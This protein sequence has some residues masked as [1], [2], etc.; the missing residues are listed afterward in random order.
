MTETRVAIV[1]AAS[2]G[3]G[4]AI[5][6]CLR[7]RGYGLALMSPSGGSVALAE[8]L[9]AL[10]LVGS[11]TA[12]ADIDRLLAATLDRYGRI[13]GVVNNT[14]RHSDVL[15]RYGFTDAPP[16]TGPNLNYDPAFEGEVL[17]VPDAAWHDDLDLMVLNVVR[18]ARATTDALKARSGGSVVNI[19]GLEGAQPRIV[20]PLGPVRLALHAFT[21]LYA[22]RYARD[23]IRM[24]CVLPGMVENARAEH[25]SIRRAIPMGRYGRFAEIAATVAFLLSDEASY[26]TGQSILVDG[27][28][29]RGF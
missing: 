28:I 26:I 6:R 14:G 5:A 3:I 8:E 12:Q 23:G 2:R 27:G 24:N 19:S 15:A 21:K 16:L 20:Y 4:E 1:T 22:D 10:G 17:D 18:M 9:G 25:P 13:D 11:V 7:D 29:N